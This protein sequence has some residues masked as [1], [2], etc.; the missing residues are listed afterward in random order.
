[1]GEADRGDAVGLLEVERGLRITTRTSP[2]TRRSTSAS[3]VSQSC[4]A[5]VGLARLVRSARR[6]TPQPTTSMASGLAL[7]DVVAPDRL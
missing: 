7:V 1:V 5:W 2:P 6:I 4:S 3:V